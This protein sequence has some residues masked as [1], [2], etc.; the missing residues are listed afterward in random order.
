MDTGCFSA[1]QRLSCHAMNPDLLKPC[2]EHGPPQPAAT[3]MKPNRTKPEQI[4]PEL[5]PVVTD[6]KTGRS[7]SKGKLLG[8]VIL[9]LIFEFDISYPIFVDIY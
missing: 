4:K 8:K 5:A 2:P 7:Y 6:P 3:P 1:A 9:I